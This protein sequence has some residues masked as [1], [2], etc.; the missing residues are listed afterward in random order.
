M[1]CVRSK[2]TLCCGVTEVFVEVCAPQA[3]I[4]V[5]V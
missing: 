3:N 4:C 5:V 1:R 2:L